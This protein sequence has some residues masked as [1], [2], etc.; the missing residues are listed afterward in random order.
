MGAH[1]SNQHF[2]GHIHE[3]IVDLARHVDRRDA[4][5][6]TTP[7]AVANPQRRLFNEIDFLGNAE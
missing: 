7:H 2:V 6:P 4:P 3:L 1:R 5:R